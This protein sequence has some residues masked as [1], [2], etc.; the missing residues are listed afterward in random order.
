MK[1]NKFIKEIITLLNSLDGVKVVDVYQTITHIR[2][3]LTIESSRSHH[4]LVYCSEAANVPLHC[5]SKHY[6]GSE[7]AMKNPSL[8]L[9]YEFVITKKESDSEEFESMSWLGSHL[10]WLM[11]DMGKIEKNKANRLLELWGAAKVEVRSRI[12]EAMKKRDT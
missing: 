11:H 7:E 5:C 2:I 6:P 1:P 10:V 9:I 12:T 4:W 8:G 3:Y